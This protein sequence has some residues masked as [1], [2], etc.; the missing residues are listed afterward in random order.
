MSASEHSKNSRE[1][2]DGTT[3]CNVRS[4]VP[5]AFAASRKRALISPHPEGGLSYV[6]RT[7]QVAHIHDLR[8][9]P[10]YRDGS[11]AVIEFADVGGAR[12]VIIVPMLKENELTGT[13]TIYRK[14]VRPTL[15]LVSISRQLPDFAI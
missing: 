8:L 13:I 9:S 11:P 3:A 7:K 12:T 6:A 14:E 2:A 4:G 5:P 10:A 1:F 15:H